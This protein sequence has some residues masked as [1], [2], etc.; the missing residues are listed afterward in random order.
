[1]LISH[2][3]RFIFVHIGRIAGTSVENSL[4]AAMGIENPKAFQGER[5]ELIDHAVA[6]NEERPSP[7]LYDRVGKKHA[8]AGALKEMV[9]AYHW[10]SYFKFSF[11][12]NP[13]DWELSRY[14]K[15]RQFRN[16]RPLSATSADRVLIAYGMLRRQ[17]L[18][19]TP[20][21]SQFDHLAINGQV[22]MDY[23]G[24]YETLDRDFY[25]IC[26]IIGLNAKLSDNNDSTRDRNSMA[27]HYRHYYNK[28][29]KSLVAFTR[30][31]DIENF[32]YSF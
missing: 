30:R 19:R 21:K 13:W 8:S 11:V 18:S 17:L 4:M 25:A 10:S 24:R 32:G 31:R 22:T 16:Q 23:I 3:H 1:M 2:E 20:T 28:A 12:R 15:G 9:G 6:R 27:N 5:R 7:E 14:L 26:R 29:S